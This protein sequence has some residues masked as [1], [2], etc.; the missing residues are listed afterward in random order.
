MPIGSSGDTQSGSVAVSKHSCLESA[1]QA[2]RTRGGT[3]S[4]HAGSPAVLIALASTVTA[5]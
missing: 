2:T 4:A 5:G 1:F 3:A